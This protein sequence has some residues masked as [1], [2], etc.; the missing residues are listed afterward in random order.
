LSHI[1]EDGDAPNRARKGFDYEAGD[2]KRKDE[3]EEVWSESD[4]KEEV[5][6]ELDEQEEVYGRI[7][8]ARG[9]MQPTIEQEEAW[10][11]ADEQ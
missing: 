9:G 6:S 4:E 8:R 2:A 1:S 7:R 5:W 11:E 10:S 3:R